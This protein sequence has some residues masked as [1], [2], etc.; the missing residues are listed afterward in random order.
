MARLLPPSCQMG[1]HRAS[2]GFQRAREAPVPGAP[3]APPSTGTA[4]AVRGDQRRPRLVLTRLS[5]APTARRLCCF[6]RGCRGGGPWRAGQT[7]RAAA[8]LLGGALPRSKGSKPALSKTGSASP[9]SVALRGLF[10]LG[11]LGVD[12]ARL[13]AS[14]PPYVKSPLCLLGLG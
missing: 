7:C 14:S 11:R 12:P 2:S 3:P 1:P 13:P 6:E 9:C 8:G 10:T 4:S 5:R